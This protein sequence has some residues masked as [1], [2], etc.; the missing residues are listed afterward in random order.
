[1]SVLCDIKEKGLAK[2]QAAG[3]LFVLEN[4][5]AKDFDSYLAGT[6]NADRGRIGVQTLC[7]SLDP[8]KDLQDSLWA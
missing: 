4:C 5:P 3:L 2:A 8:V 6:K 1:M 7:S